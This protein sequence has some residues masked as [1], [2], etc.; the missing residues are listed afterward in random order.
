MR[1]EPSNYCIRNFIFDYTYRFQVY[2]GKVQAII[3]LTLS[4]ELLEN[5]R[6]V[7]TTKAMWTAIKNV[8]ERHTLL[9]KLSAR[10]KFY[11]ATMKSE[12]SVLQFSNRIRQLGATLKS[13]NVVISE[14]EMAM[15]L[16]NG[17]PDE[18]NALISAL[19]AID[20]WKLWMMGE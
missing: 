13:M 17:L 12:E 19:H 1:L 3:G 18:Y 15:S 10:K 14:S 8:F 5:V 11:T 6:E 2:Y 16:L 7:E 4:D 9:N 20:Y